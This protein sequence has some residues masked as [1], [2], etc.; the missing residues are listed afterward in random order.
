MTLK[1]ILI[2]GKLT[3]SEGGG[4]G[5]VAV[6]KWMDAPE[7]TD[8][9]LHIWINV[10]VED[11]KSIKLR[12]SGTGDIDWGDGSTDSSVNLNAVHIYADFGVYEIVVNGSITIPANDQII[13]C[14]SS[15][16][17]YV[18]RRLIRRIY[19]PSTIS[20]IGNYK[21]QM[22]RL[23]E[24]AT[25]NNS[26]AISDYAFQNCTGLK[27]IVIGDSVTE[28]KACAF[29]GVEDTLKVVVGASVTTIGNNAFY[30]VRAYEWHFKPTTPP[31][32][33]NT[34]AFNSTESSAVFYVPAASVD[35]YK[36]AANWSNY[37]SRIQAEP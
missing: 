10:D 21:L 13:T 29:M 2:A 12:L 14:S 28:I 11:Q 19:I 26:G 20:D 17:N 7:P 24:R 23:L 1:E 9:K 31:T 27:E 34:N 15:N 8:N 37:A 6:S 36:A 30:N 16:G 5:S 4:G 3:V 33:A 18:Q 25:I 22:C 35:A 32:L